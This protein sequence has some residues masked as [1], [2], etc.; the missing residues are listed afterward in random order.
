LNEG[1]G[2]TE[3]LL[4]FANDSF[5]P[6]FITTQGID[7]K[8][9]NVVLEG[10]RIKVQIWDSAGQERFRT[11]TTS[12]F[13]GAQ[14]ILLVYDVTDRSSFSSIRN[15]FAQIR[16]HTDVNVNLALAGN[17]CENE[18]CRAVSESEGQA[19]AAEYDVPFFETSYKLDINV[20]AAFHTLIRSVLHRLLENVP[21]PPLL[22]ES[23]SGNLKK[24]QQLLIGGAAVNEVDGKVGGND[25]CFFSARV[26]VNLLHRNVL[27]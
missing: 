16:M 27:H 25:V 20:E 13:R 18:D 15:W 14:G 22:Q 26:H 6:T 3:L 11:I 21:L 5:S 4:R 7:F 19:L 8:I 23:H 1:V 24:V 12:Y 10:K 2:K 9:K 17:N